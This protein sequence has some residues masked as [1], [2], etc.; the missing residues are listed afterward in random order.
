MKQFKINLNKKGG[1][2]SMLFGTLGA[3]LLG[4]VLAIKEWIDQE[5][6]LLELVM[7]LQLKAR[8][9]NTVSSFN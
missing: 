9:F 3:N 6:G 1:F 4:N 5:K 8:I 2:L 7:N